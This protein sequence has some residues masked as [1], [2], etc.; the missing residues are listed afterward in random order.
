M[1]VA[2][3]KE[4]LE[5]QVFRALDIDLHAIDAGKALRGQKV[6]QRQGWGLHSLCRGGI[7]H[8]DARFALVAR[9]KE[10]GQFTGLVGDGAGDGLDRAERIEADIVGQLGKDA[11]LRLDGQNARTGAGQPRHEQSISPDIGPDIDEVVAV[12]RMV[13]HVAAQRGQFLDVEMLR[14]EQHA[15]FADIALWVDAHAGA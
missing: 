13:L 9:I 1:L 5:D 4:G 12:A 14:H 11:R 2:G 10:Q 8:P 7:E 3:R 15:L 6:D